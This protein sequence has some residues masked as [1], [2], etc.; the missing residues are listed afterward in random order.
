M[1]LSIRVIEQAAREVKRLYA[2]KKH[3]EKVNTQLLEACKL[4]ASEIKENLIIE[5]RLTS[6]QVAFVEAKA[7]I[8]AAEGKAD[9]R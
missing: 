7:A 9:G 1:E 2:E 4:V 6:F 3:L 8:E 5:G